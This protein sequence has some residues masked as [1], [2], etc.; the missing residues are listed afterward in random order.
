MRGA[1]RAAGARL[2]SSGILRH[3]KGNSTDSPEMADDLQARL[4]ALEEQEEE[5]EN[6]AQTSRVQ[7]QATGGGAQAKSATLRRYQQKD[8]RERKKSASESSSGESYNSDWED[9]RAHVKVHGPGYRDDSASEEGEATAAHAKRKAFR[10]AKKIERQR[11]RGASP[12]LRSSQAFEP[13]ASDDDYQA[14]AQPER[15]AQLERPKKSPP[16]GKT[17]KSAKPEK[18]KT[19]PKGRGKSPKEAETRA[20]SHAD[21]WEQLAQSTALGDMSRADQTDAKLR[22]L[23]HLSVLDDLNAIWNNEHNALGLTPDAYGSDTPRYQRTFHVLQSAWKSHLGHAKTRELLRAVRTLFS[24]LVKSCGGPPAHWSHQ[25]PLI[26]RQRLAFCQW[27]VLNAYWADPKLIGALFP[28]G[29]IN[30][31]LKAPDAMQQGWV[32]AHAALRAY[33]IPPAMLVAFVEARCGRG[34]DPLTATGKEVCESYRAE[35]DAATP[36]Y[37]EMSGGA[38]PEHHEA[39]AQAH[40]QDIAE[41]A[42]TDP[43]DIW[44]QDLDEHERDEPTSRAPPSP[45][46]WHAPLSAATAQQLGIGAGTGHSRSRSRSRGQ[47]PSRARG[48]SPSQS[49]APAPAPKKGSRRKGIVL[50]RY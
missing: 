49:R 43:M 37:E 50:P 24:E 38:R 40:Q 14:P 36:G 11:R 26:C 17:K 35:K 20:D 44:Q 23:P 1:R 30:P 6:N 4:R 13:S 7:R 39:D 21:L 48:R 16:P 28:V 19:P 32:A 31:R 42:P 29:E 15:Q 8:E 2:V 25:T 9:R 27:A 47:S 12:V 33:A 3:L 46:S 45:S 22:E 34:G 18:Q 5:M 41:R 10:H